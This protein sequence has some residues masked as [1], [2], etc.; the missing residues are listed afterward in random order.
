[1][2]KLLTILL[3]CL[4]VFAVVGC[5]ASEEEGGDNSEKS[6][7]EQ[8]KE[9]GK[10]TIA[11]VVNGTIGDKSFFDS[12]EEGMQLINANLGDKMYGETIELSYNKDT[13]ASGME[14]VFKQ[15]WAIIIAGTYDMKEHVI[16]LLEQYPDQK[17]W[18]YDEEWNFDNADCWQ[19]APT[20][21]L[22]A[23]MFSQN[24][25]SYLVGYMAAMLTQTGYISFMGGMDN[26][27]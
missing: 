19:Y 25:G 3:A 6:P 11:N 4:M 8:A 23:M 24:E 9:A 18:F 20:D 13:W 10:I 5:T 26:T 27:V 22:Y 12:G 1:M 17:V 7:M 15:G 16:P 14:E 21:K 2:K